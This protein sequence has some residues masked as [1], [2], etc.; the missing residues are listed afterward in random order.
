MGSGFMQLLMQCGAH[1]PRRLMAEHNHMTH[2]ESCVPM[3]I[4]G[5]YWSVFIEELLRLM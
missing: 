5:G 1:L 3:D 2:A 4:A